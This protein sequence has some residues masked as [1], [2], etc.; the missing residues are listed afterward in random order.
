MTKEDIAQ[1]DLEIE[2]VGK[3]IIKRLVDLQITPEVDQSKIMISPATLFKPANIVYVTCAMVVEEEF[4]K[5]CDM[6]FQLYWDHKSKMLDGAELYPQY[7][8]D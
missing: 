4:A 1:R 7:W 5:Q 3:H 8:K 6:I 2:W